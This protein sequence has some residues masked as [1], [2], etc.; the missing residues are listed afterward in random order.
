MIDADEARASGAGDRKGRNRGVCEHIDA[1]RL[2]EFAANTV[3]HDRHV[4]RCLRSDI[5]R[6]GE[7]NVAMILDDHAVASAIEIGSRIVESSLIDRLHRLA[8]I[9]RCSRKR[10][11]VNDAD[12]HLGA[13][14][15]LDER[16]AARLTDWR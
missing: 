4:G 5:V 1:D 14:E 15:K 13:T 2:A 8:V 9:A 6:F 3:G 12:H 10:R 7:G 16:V 11:E